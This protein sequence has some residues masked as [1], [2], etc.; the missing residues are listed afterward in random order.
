MKRLL[1][2]VSGTAAT[3]AFA[4]FGAA[5]AQNAF[6]FDR[7]AYVTCREAHAMAPDARRTLATQLAEHSARY[8]GVVLPDDD[9]GAQIAYL[10]RGGCTLSPESYLFVVIDRAIQAESA[11]LPK[12]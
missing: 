4:A 12:R 2:A 9:R 1:L 11:R 10:V 6:V 3:A 5:E 8:R 7:A